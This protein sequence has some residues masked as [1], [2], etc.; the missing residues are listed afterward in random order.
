M[1]KNSPFFPTFPQEKLEKLPFKKVSM[2]DH[3]PLV[4]HPHISICS[5]KVFVFFTFCG[6]ISLYL[7]DR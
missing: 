1:V 6:I 7:G 2:Q 3:K 5:S 4:I